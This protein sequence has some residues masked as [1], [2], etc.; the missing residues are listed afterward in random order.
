MFG[1]KWDE[2]AAF[3]CVIVKNSKTY[4]LLTLPW[5]NVNKCVQFLLPFVE[6]TLTQNHTE[7]MLPLGI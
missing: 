7:T 4:T 6:L 1:R 2:I 5:L 3:S